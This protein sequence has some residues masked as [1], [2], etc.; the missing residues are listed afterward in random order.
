MSR[1]N[2]AA[3]A[4]TKTEN[5]AGGEA[6][7][8]TPEL[9]FVS[10]LL[11]SF[12]KDQFYKK[13]DD[14]IT[15]IKELVK[16]I[17]PLFA[18]K[19]AIY[20]RNEFGMRSVSHVVAGEIA[21]TVK[22][23]EWTKSFFEKIVR[24]PDDMMEIMSY[25][26]ANYGKNEPN[27]LRKGFAKALAHFDEYSLAKYKGEGKEVSLI[28]IV[29][30]VHPPHTE[31]IKALID[32]TLK[33]AETWETKLSEA[34]K[35][36]DDVDEAKTGAWKSLLKGKKLGY[37]ALLKNMRNI[38]QTGDQELIGIA[39]EQ[40]VDEKKIKKSLVLPFRFLTASEEIAKIN[41]E[42]ARKVL[43]AINQAFD[44]SAQNVPK[45]DGKTLV[46]LD[47]SG[48]M[49]G[50]PYLI[51]SLFAALLIK[52]NDADYMAFADQAQYF[53]VNP[54]DST[55]T[56]ANSLRRMNG[57][58]NFHA[59]FQEA[60]RAYDR[61]I[62]LSDMQA[63]VDFNAPTAEFNNFVSRVGKRPRVYSF[64]LA[65]HGTMQFPQP[66]VFAI[67]GFS[68]KIFDIMKI[69]EQDKNALINTIKAVEL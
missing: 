16:T 13:A 28:D 60:N 57:G 51:G 24:R 50:Q 27:S 46:V 30:T 29:N 52:S 62:I 9:E 68:E 53:T 7:L 34:G 66:E 44:L 6:F 19:A 23:K 64:D 15:R 2:S 40:L 56:I 8:Q 47:N 69:L 3:S 10:I 58:T 45:F 26:Y 39:C 21:G 31:A 65:G 14:S 17:D 36:E 55:L 22:G 41:D 59:I 67:A 1:F 38:V 4:A 48:S 18:A 20:A 11:T 61:I 25:Y 12:M 49:N 54:L 63:W 32:G 37:M 33:P 5:L 35:S 43:V 42:G